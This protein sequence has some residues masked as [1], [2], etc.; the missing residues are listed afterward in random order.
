VVRGR[1][2]GLPH[3]PHGDGLWFL[4]ASQCLHG[5]SSAPGSRLRG[6]SQRRRARASANVPIRL[7]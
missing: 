1:Q 3:R 5:S 2:V 6:R 7:A 4:P